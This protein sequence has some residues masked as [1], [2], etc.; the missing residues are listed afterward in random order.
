M[1]PDEAALSMRRLWRA[2]KMWL[3][4]TIIMEGDIAFWYI[5]RYYR[6]A[7]A[8]ERNHQRRLAVAHVAQDVQ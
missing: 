7:E 4:L 2:C 6:R 3:Y 5:L 1:P 8:E